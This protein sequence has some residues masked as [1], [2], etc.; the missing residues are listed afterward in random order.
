MTV[1]V[2][3]VP[4][5]NRSKRPREPGA[6]PLNASKRAR[7]STSFADFEQPKPVCEQMQGDPWGEGEDEAGRL[8]PVHSDLSFTAGI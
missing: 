7:K 8:L 3:G 2:T 5:L 6:E 1:A 4:G